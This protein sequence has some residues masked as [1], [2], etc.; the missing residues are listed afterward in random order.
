MDTRLERLEQKFDKKFGSP[1][2]GMQGGDD[3]LRNSFTAL[4]E[5]IA[6]A[7]IWAL[8]LYFAFAASMLGT[9]ARGFGWV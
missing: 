7:K 8:V 4:R 2:E 1:K 5:E 6:A 9:M 3:A